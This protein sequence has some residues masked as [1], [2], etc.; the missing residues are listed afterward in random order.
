VAAASRTTDSV[1][2][3]VTSRIGTSGANR[4]LN[5]IRLFGVMAVIHRDDRILRWRRMVRR[6]HFRMR[7]GQKCN[8]ENIDFFVV[9]VVN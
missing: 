2:D 8:V 9:I 6:V 4:D 3:P 7:R 1:N 5:V